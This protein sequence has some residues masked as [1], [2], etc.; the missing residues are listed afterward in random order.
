MPDFQ[1]G[2]MVGSN[3][4]TDTILIGHYFYV[5][6]PIFT[7]I[8]WDEKQNITNMEIEQRRILFTL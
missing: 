4:P 5:N 1:S 7:S 8:Y 2:D 6:N 3:P